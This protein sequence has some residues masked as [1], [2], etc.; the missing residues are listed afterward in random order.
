M[1]TH[2]SLVEMIFT[3]CALV[4]GRD[5]LGR[6]EGLDLEEVKA[7]WRRE[8]S[9]LL[10]RPASILYGLN[11]LPERP[12][13]VLQFRALCAAR[14]GDVAAARAGYEEVLQSQSEARRLEAERALRRL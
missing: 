1:S 6:W 5:F 4:Y 9:H 11:H 7:D 10:A 2:E 12:P 8:L 3:K 13:N 14:A